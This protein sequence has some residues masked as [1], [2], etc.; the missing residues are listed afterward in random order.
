MKKQKGFTLVEGLLIVLIVSVVGFAGYTVRRNQESDDNEVV[1]T[2]QVEEQRE[3]PKKDGEQETVINETPAPTTNISD[4]LFSTGYRNE[5]IGLLIDF[6]IG[7][8]FS[9]YWVEYGQTPDALNSQTEKRSDGLVYAIESF[10]GFTAI[11]DPADLPDGD[12]IY[13]YRIAATK[14]G[15]VE[16]TGV[17]A[18]NYK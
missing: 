12:N 5:D 16:Y 6:L 14:D 15:A 17:S 9:D 11:I 13:F 4:E 3:E 7:P 1:E 8:G 18:F 10:G 2:S